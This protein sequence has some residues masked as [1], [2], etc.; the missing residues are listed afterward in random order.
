MNRERQR[1]IEKKTEFLLKEYAEIVAEFF[2]GVLDLDHLIEEFGRQLPNGQDSQARVLDPE[3]IRAERKV[4]CAAAAALVGVWWMQQ[5]PQLAPLFMVETL[6]T[7]VIHKTAAH[8][9]VVLPTI[10]EPQAVHWTLPKNLHRTAPTKSYATYSI[11]GV[12]HF[13]HDRVGVYG[14][15]SKYSTRTGLLASKGPPHPVPSAPE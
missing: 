11:S 9:I 8:V 7:R 14:L 3:S 12:T 13:M 15:P 5:F 10:D 6:G 4:N 1:S 2:P